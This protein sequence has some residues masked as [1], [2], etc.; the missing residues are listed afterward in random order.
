MTAETIAKLCCPIDKSDLISEVMIRD[1]NQNI[2]MGKLTCNKCNRVYPVIHGV[3]VMVPDEYRQPALEQ[4][5]V[6]QYQLPGI[7]DAD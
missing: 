5:V 6:A 3:P 2:L 4:Q 7:A 1:I